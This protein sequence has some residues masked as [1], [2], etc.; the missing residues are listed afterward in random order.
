MEIIIQFSL[1][2]TS[3]YSTCILSQRR[4]RKQVAVIKFVISN[5]MDFYLSISYYFSSVSHS[6][7]AA[8]YSTFIFFFTG[9]TQNNN[10]TEILYIP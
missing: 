3:A 7:D 2:Q 6:F 10:K 4:I 8:L 1:S 5:N 9:N